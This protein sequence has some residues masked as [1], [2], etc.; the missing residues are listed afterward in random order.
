MD[1]ISLIEK[2]TNKEA[3]KAFLPMQPGDVFETYADSSK[4][5]ELLGFDY[6]TRLESGLTSFYNW[7]LEYHGIKTKELQSHE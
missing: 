4:I 5:K 7:Y 6:A 3:N 2:I 1:F